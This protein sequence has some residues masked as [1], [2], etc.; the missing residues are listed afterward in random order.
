[1]HLPWAGM[2]TLAAPCSNPGLFNALLLPVRTDPVMHLRLGPPGRIGRCPSGS[3]SASCGCTPPVTAHAGVLVPVVSDTAV[4]RRLT[5]AQMTGS[6]WWCILHQA[7]L[8]THT[9]TRQSMS[10]AFNS[11]TSDI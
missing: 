4:C 10:A 1:M 11:T 7:R 2:C 3:R 5:Q 6:E 9:C 8:H